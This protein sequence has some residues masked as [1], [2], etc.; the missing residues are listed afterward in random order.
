L[1]FRSRQISISRTGKVS[2]VRHPPKARVAAD[3]LCV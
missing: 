3:V 1:V 2:V